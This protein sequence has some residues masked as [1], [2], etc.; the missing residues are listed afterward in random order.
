[1]CEGLWDNKKN[2]EVAGQHFMY[3][4]IQNTSV[5][6]NKKASPMIFSNM[7]QGNKKEK[8]TKT[9]PKTIFLEVLIT[10]VSQHC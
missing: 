3:A 9:T 7:L 1:M 4:F 10:L 6:L 5:C 2:H 8:K